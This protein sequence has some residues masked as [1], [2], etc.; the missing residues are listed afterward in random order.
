MLRGQ[1][2]RQWRG[3][4][5]LHFDH[6]DSI[7]TLETSYRMGCGICRVLYEEVETSASKQNPGKESEKDE[8]Q[9]PDH[10]GNDEA[11]IGRLSAHSTASLGVINDIEETGLFRLDFKL[12]WAL[13]KQSSNI[14]KRTFVLK[15]TGTRGF[16]WNSGLL[17]LI[18]YCRQL[19]SSIQN[20]HVR[21]NVFK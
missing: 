17:K 12:K 19:N 15:Q 11:E 3:T 20:S 6:H 5:D 4:Y 14:L 16:V 2:G 21:A 10:L 1:V 18:H 7:E 8:E 13:G 9:P